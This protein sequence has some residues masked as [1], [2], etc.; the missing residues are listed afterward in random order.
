MYRCK[1]IIKDGNQCKRN[2]IKKDY[3]K[4]H[5]FQKDK[6][7]I[8]SLSCQLIT[9]ICRSIDPKTKTELS[10]S[11]RYFYNLLKKNKIINFNLYPYYFRKY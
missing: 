11:C 6:S 9:N 7:K 1:G 10:I 3:C 8:C 5:E 4:Q 2:I